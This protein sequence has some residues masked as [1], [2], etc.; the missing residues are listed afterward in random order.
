MVG[1]GSAETGR[2]Y[3]DSAPLLARLVVH[4][5]VLELLNLFSTLTTVDSTPLSVHLR[6]PSGPSGPV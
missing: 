6:C 1:S 4:V 3:T 5:V 2:P